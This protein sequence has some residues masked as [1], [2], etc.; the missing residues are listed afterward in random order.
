M[1]FFKKLKIVLFAPS[2]LPQK[3]DTSFVFP[4]ATDKELKRQQIWENLQKGILWEE[5]GILIPWSTAYDDLRKFAAE[6]TVKGD[7][8]IW[9]LGSHQIL[10]GYTCEPDVQKWAFISDLE[11]FSRIKI[12]LGYDQAGTEVFLKLKEKLT[13]LLGAPSSVDAEDRAGVPLDIITW[14]N[15]GVMI[16]LSG[17]DQH[18]F[19]YTLHIGL[20]G[21]DF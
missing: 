10:D 2:P 17:I 13:D 12:W 8:T 7:R 20:T 19:K 14:E 21:N 9:S 11:P 3:R 6:K 5:S 15:K 16:K 1:N 4:Y 18:V